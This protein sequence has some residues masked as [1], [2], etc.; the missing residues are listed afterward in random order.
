MQMTNIIKIIFT[1]VLAWA[2]GNAMGDQPIY[3]QGKADVLYSAVM[4]TSED[5]RQALNA[6]K[7]KAIESYFSEQNSAESRNFDAVEE[8]VKT[9]LD[10]YLIG[11]VVL[12]E[13]DA[14]DSKRYTVAVRVQL[15]S[16]RIVELMKPKTAEKSGN[17]PELAFLFLTRQVSTQISFD[18][19]VV[20]R[21]EASK[22]A[23][24]DSSVNEISNESES[25]KKSSVGTGSSALTK[26][27]SN[28]GE[29]STVE[30]GGSI[31]KKIAE[32]T[33]KLGSSQ[34]FNA[35]FLEVINGQDWPYDP[36]EAETEPKI[37][38]KGVK[39]D[40]SAGDDIQPETLQLLV[41]D[42]KSA[43][44][45]YLA[46]GTVSIG[47]PGT[48]PS[49]GLSRVSVELYAKVYDF[50]GRRSKTIVTVGPEVINGE[51]ADPS[52]AQANAI[53]LA[54]N[55]AAKEFMNQLSQKDVR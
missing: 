13:E 10:R 19:R 17:R 36:I 37:N 22:K 20:K 8:Q 15:N 42:L 32:S 26:V 33:Y 2:C 49:T 38:L 52:Q 30:T 1:I 46:L 6:A 51:G 44:L 35:A 41:R 40:F 55:R 34:S 45:N 4:P 7:F 14:K 23:N 9:D 16:N 5:K 27:S 25:I 21:I 31:Q 47:L 11:V 39:T 3:S 12:G 18:D 29:I 54:A 24:G 53:K 28:E 48:D 50:S 43:E